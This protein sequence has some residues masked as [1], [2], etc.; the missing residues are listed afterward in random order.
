MTPCAKNSGRNGIPLNTHI[1][2][3]PSNFTE[4]SFEIHL[5]Q[6][7]REQVEPT[8]HHQLLAAGDLEVVREKGAAHVWEGILR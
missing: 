6:G 8:D 4:D 5:Q 2:R 7:S 3:Y 1:S